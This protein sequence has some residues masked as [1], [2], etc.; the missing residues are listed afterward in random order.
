MGSFSI[1]H[2]L[3][4]APLLLL[5]TAIF[6]VLYFVLRKHLPSATQAISHA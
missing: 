5:L 2:W 4:G 6:L 3:T 1:W